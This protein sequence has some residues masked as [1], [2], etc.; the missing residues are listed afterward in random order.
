MTNVLDVV[1][2]NNT[3]TGK[4]KQ[5]TVIAILVASRSDR[6]SEKKSINIPASVGPPPKPIIFRM[7]KN[8]AVDIAR[9]WIG[10]SVWAI[11]KLGPR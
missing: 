4:M 8:N 10:A 1:M 11:A 9:M 3:E 2:K 6:P 5:I 7:K